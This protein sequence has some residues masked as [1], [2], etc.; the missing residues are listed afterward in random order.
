M[1]ATNYLIGRGEL[2]VE[3][4]GPP[5]IRPTKQ[6]PYSIE[7]SRSRLA[8][9]LGEVLETFVGNE[10]AAP[11][12]VHVTRF[13]LHP[14]YIAKSYYPSK[15][16]RAVGL[17]PVGSR[18]TTIQPGAHTV[19]GWEGTDFGT[20][21]IFV[22]GKRASFE[23]LFAA[24]TSSDVL[25]DELAEIREIEAIAPFDA[26]EKVKPLTSAQGPAVL[27][28]VLHLPS[29]W[30]TP[31]NQVSFLEFANL[32]GFVVETELAFTV[33][34]LWFVPVTGP[35]E[36]VQELASYT[37]VRVVR[38][39][40]SLT[41]SPIMRTLGPVV[42]GVSLP[43]G[44]ALSSTP[45]VAILDG[46]LPQDHP[47]GRWIES[48][49]E[50][51]PNAANSPHYERH[52]LAVASAFLFGSLPGSGVADVPP[53][54][55]SVFRVLDSSSDAQDPFEL[56]R[57]LG[58]VEEILLARS[59]D[60]VNLSLGPTLPVED[61]DVHAWTAL[62]DDL[63]DDG[64]TLMTVAVGNTGENDWPSGNARVQVP[65]DAVNALAVGAS[66][67]AGAEWARAPYSSVGPGRSPG[68]VK[69]D[70]LAHGGSELEPFHVLSPGVSPCSEAQLGT[71]LA[72]PFA[73][74]Q[75][76][77]IRSLLGDD[78]TPLALRSLLIHGTDDLGLPRREVGWGR[79]ASSLDDI[80]VSPSG[81][82][83]VVYQGEVKPGKYVRAKVP[84][85][86]GG[87]NGMIS[88]KATFC[89][90]SPIDAQS[91]DSYTRAGLEVRFRRDTGLIKP[92]S[93]TPSTTSFF[94]PASY[95]D[96]A[97]LRNDEGKWETV[98][99][100]QKNMQGATLAA[101]VFDIHYNARDE[102]GQ[103]RVTEALKY[104]LVITVEAPQHV[105][106]HNEIL[107]AY[108][109]LLVAIEPDVEVTLT[110]QP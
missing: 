79:V 43:A 50:M 106:L 18:A 57:T 74:R 44:P 15:L 67:S 88:L 55:I 92:G 22:A 6:H 48:Y 83:R 38:P 30:M 26:S 64:S 73:L 13:V 41:V 9:G 104:A 56:Y 96:E 20:S 89:F 11:D 68:L 75:A 25:S 24:L 110:G 5:R 63:L 61:T 17:E 28:L 81:V 60:F 49:Q 84:I 33:R 54:K 40:P 90:A 29:N 32:H 3:P 59:F 93:N 16:F 45:K 51:D 102:G 19:K 99:K 76:V 108:P 70:V 109:D 72:A 97:A 39:M 10:R 100:A 65:S 14:A 78:L 35:A 53:S 34:G 87:L 107:N 94:S 52:G 98:L 21:E 23:R 82:A 71:S 62:I 103:S 27:E 58:H 69:P 77:S 66:D 36:R 47:L 4:V 37:T 105:N 80:V 8:A 91:P 95:S 85:P 31:S 46:G 101:P 2:L 42:D 86:I 1:A 12:G 7:E